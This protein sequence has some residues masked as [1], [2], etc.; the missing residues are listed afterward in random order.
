MVRP[1][2]VDN[3]TASIHFSESSSVT[4]LV[5][6]SDIGMFLPTKLPSSCIIA[7]LKVIFKY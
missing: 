4:G 1:A 3:L 5:P 7:I 2:D 6:V